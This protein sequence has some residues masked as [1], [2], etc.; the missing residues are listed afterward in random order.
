MTR[1]ELRRAEEERAR[2]RVLLGALFTSILA[3]A[4]YWGHLRLSE[5]R[6]PYGVKDYYTG[7]IRNH[8]GDLVD[9]N[10]NVLE[11]AKRPPGRTAMKMGP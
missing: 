2:L 10:G 7:P 11:Y 6:I 8:R 1:A 9:I 5:S 3:L 4:I